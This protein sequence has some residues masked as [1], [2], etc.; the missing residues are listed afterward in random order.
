MDG[1][2]LTFHVP[3]LNADTE[4]YF[5]VIAVNEE[6]QSQPLETSDYTKLPKKV[7][8]LNSSFEIFSSIV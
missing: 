1:S 4:Y 5:R 6:G 3:N 7:G 2:T 8:K